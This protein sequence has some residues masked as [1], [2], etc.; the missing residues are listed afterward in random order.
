MRNLLHFCPFGGD[1][2]LAVLNLQTVVD[3]SQDLSDLCHAIAFQ[4]WRATPIPLGEPLPEDFEQH[5]LAALRRL[6]ASLDCL[7]RRGRYILIL[8]EYELLDEKLPEAAAN[9]FITLLRGLTQQYPWLVIGLVG[10]HNL[11]E[12][13]AGFYQAIFAWRPIK[14]G[15][16]DEGSFADMLQVEDDNFLLEYSPAALARAY[17]LTG[18]QPFL[19]QLLGD[20][21]CNASTGNS[22]FSLT[23]RCLPFQ[24]RM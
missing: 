23:R 21:W 9:D 12:R 13:S 16:L 2:G 5:P 15:L 8:D 1:T 7:E 11:R 22:G 19:G 18:G 17:A 20:A 4:L 10:L 3:W 24:Q 6:L 14:V